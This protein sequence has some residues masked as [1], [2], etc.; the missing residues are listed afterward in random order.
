MRRAIALN[1]KLG[2]SL[3][4]FDK[5]FL[6]HFLKLHFFFMPA[7]QAIAFHHIVL[8]NVV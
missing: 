3:S 8:F 6:D 2:F 4:C 1:R 5:F 7:L